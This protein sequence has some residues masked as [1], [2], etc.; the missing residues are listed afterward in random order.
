MTRPTEQ[1][2]RFSLLAMHS[3]EQ[4]SVKGRSEQKS[5]QCPGHG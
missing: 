3:Q 5:S 2:F 1:V 4:S